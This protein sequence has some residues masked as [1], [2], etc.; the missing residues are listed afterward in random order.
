MLSEIVPK[1]LEGKEN[2]LFVAE[3]APDGCPFR[4]M[5]AMEP[6]PEREA[7]NNGGLISHLHYQYG[8]SKEKLL[9]DGKLANPMWYAT[10]CDGDGTLLDE[11]NIVRA[12]HRLPRWDSIPG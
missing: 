5:L 10:M 3:S 6:M 4:Y 12:L 8:S 2:F 9:K 7:K 1:G 11:C